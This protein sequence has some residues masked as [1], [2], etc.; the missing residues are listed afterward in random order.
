MK[1]VKENMS[2][3]SDC[4]DGEAEV[5]VSKLMAE[6]FMDH[7]YAAMEKFEMIEDL[8][9]AYKEEEGTDLFE[10]CVSEDEEFEGSYEL[11]KQI[12]NYMF[13]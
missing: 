8:I 5:F 4:Y 7:L 12:K 11:L 2:I 13:A 3:I 1:T 10:T 9:Q 6:I